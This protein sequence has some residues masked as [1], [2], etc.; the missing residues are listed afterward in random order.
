MHS[1]FGTLAGE[2]IGKESAAIGVHRHCCAARLGP[3]RSSA[4]ADR[5]VYWSSVCERP[6]PS[7]L[8]AVSRATLGQQKDQKT[9]QDGQR[10][11]IA[12]CGSGQRIQRFPT[13]FD[14]ASVALV[15]RSPR[16]IRARCGGSLRLADVTLPENGLVPGSSSGPATE[17]V[18]RQAPEQARTSRSCSSTSRTTATHLLGLTRHPSGGRPD[19]DQRQSISSAQ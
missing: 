17:C 4:G 19:G 6:E 8:F 10:S 3:W 18:Q 13:S 5:S 14:A 9:A 11:P 1:P 2:N 15:G 16:F 12:N 7:R